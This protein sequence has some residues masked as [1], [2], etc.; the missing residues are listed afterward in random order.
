MPAPQYD[1]DNPE[2]ISQGPSICLFNKEDAG[3]VM[4]SWIFAQFLLTNRVQIDYATTEGYIPVTEKALNSDEYRD[5][6][7]R[8]GENNTRY[9]QVK[10]DA[11][12]MLIENIENT[13]ITPVFNGSTSLRNAAGQMIEEVNKGVRRKKTVDDAYIDELFSEMTSLY[14]LDQISTV[15]GKIALGELP[16]G[17][18][19]LLWTLGVTWIC[20]AAYGITDHIKKKKLLKNGKTH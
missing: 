3:E 18:K 1:P 8:G 9:Y 17:S 11:T 7:S 5:Y 15:D 12:H 4:A 10:M 2:M 13:F 19:A 6:L 14:R 16:T 20:I